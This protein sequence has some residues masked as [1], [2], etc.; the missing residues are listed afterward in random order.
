M[1]FFRGGGNFCEMGVNLTNVFCVA[2]A[3]NSCRLA[4]HVSFFSGDAQRFF[5]PFVSVSLRN[6]GRT[7]CFVTMLCVVG[8]LL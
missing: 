2:G 7:A 1:E 5:V 6:D 4:L 8:I 3:M